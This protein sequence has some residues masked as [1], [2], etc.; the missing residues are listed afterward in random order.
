MR[1]AETRRPSTMKLSSPLMSPTN[2]QS[3]DEARKKAA[4]DR[5]WRLV[6]VAA[7]GMVISTL[8]AGSL[9]IW[10]LIDK[11]TGITHYVVLAHNLLRGNLTLDGMPGPMPDV[12]TYNGHKYL[13]LGPLPAVLLIPFL[14]LLDNGVRLVWVG[15]LLTLV[16][17][18]LLY[19]ILKKIDVGSE[20]RKWSLLLFFG[21]T[22]YMGLAFE[23]STWG[24]DQMA[25]V[26]FLLAAMLEGVNGKRPLLMGLLLGLAGMARFTAIFALPFFVVLLW[27]AAQEGRASLAPAKLFG[28]LAP[29][30]MGL[31]IPLALLAL[32]N[33]ARFGNVLDTGYGRAEFGESMLERARSYGMFSLVHVPKNLVMM[34][35]QGPEAYPSA[36]AP[37]LQFPYLQPSHW[38]MGIFFTSPT[39]VY[40]FR[41]KLREPLVLACWL[42]VICVMVPIITYYGIGWE[43]VGYRYALDFTPFLVLLAARGMPNP[44]NNTARVLVLI[45]LLVGL[46]ACMFLSSMGR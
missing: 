45:S 29:L 17:V 3:A 19:R 14:P 34:L 4:A 7:A 30:L 12:A 5:Y 37:V 10:P 20:Q 33:Y 46:W 42:A 6:F 36:D 1:S 18:W 31:A 25:T 32:Y 26:T 21:G 16:N 8:L 15:H 39:L 38:G 11:S 44:M 43:Q 23:G 9:L 27:K 40:I 35:F 28:K 2:R 22:V 41:T 24:L 13:P